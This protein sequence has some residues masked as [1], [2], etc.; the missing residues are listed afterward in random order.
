M[1]PAKEIRLQVRATDDQIA[2]FKSAAEARGLSVSAWVR[3]TL[4][5]AAQQYEQERKKAPDGPINRL[6][7]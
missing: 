6:T 7:E 4:L 5:D 2:A 1:N 3:M